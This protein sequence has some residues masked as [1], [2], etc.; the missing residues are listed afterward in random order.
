M[1]GTKTSDV[2]RAVGVDDPDFAARIRERDAQSLEEVVR[3]YAAIY[4]A[5]IR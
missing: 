5:E 3:L 1:A 2:G 4:D